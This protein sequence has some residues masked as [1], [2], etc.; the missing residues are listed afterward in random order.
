MLSQGFGVLKF[1][2]V[3][4]GGGDRGV[5]GGDKASRVTRTGAVFR[6]FRL[7]EVP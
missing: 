3:Q 6:R 2:T 1:M 7:D 4:F 5:P